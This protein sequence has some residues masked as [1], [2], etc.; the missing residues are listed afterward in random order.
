MNHLLLNVKGLTILL[1]RRRIPFQ[2]IYWVEFQLL[3]HHLPLT[4]IPIRETN[5]TP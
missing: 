1:P 4:G 3:L 5:T 2:R